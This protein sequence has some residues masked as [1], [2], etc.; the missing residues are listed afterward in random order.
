MK[1]SSTGHGLQYQLRDIIHEN[2]FLTE[3][4]VNVL[5]STAIVRVVQAQT[6]KH[7]C[8]VTGRWLQNALG[9]LKRPDCLE[10]TE[11][12]SRGK[13]YWRINHPESK[14]LLGNDSGKRWFASA[15]YE[16]RQTFKSELSRRKTTTISLSNVHLIETRIVEVQSEFEDASCKRMAGHVCLKC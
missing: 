15:L 8:I 2:C 6:V 1:I 14:L 16:W 7:D 4:H 3:K 10:G 13:E 12:A 11:I 5:P 9:I